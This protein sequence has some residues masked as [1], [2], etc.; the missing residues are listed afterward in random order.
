MADINE[1]IRGLKARPK[2][3]ITI[4]AA[5]AN[6]D[7]TQYKQVGAVQ[8]LTVDS[9]RAANERRELDY[10]GTGGKIVETFPGL[11]EYDITLERVVL[12]SGGL[13][14][15]LGFSSDFDILLQNRP[16]DIKLTMHDPDGRYDSV[17]T[18]RGVWFLDNP[19]SFDVERVDDV[20]II[21]NV[22]AKATSIDGPINK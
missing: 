4:E 13:L 1:L 10:H 5:G 3:Y 22:K 15:E 21:Q 18:L 6:G 20:R 9:T 8:K 14:K 19:M 16:V 2:C 17:W 11:P 7:L 12:Y